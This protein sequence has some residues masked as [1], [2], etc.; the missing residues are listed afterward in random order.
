AVTLLFTVAL[1]FAYFQLYNF[2]ALG[3]ELDAER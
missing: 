2:A 1:T 3:L